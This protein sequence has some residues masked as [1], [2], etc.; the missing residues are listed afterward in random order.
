MAT[1]NLPEVALHVETMGAGEAL[2]FISGLGGNASFWQP[3]AE[4]FAKNYRVV[5]HDHRGTGASSRLATAYS[6]E[7]MAQDV[8][9]LMDALEIEKAH[10]VGHSTGGAIGQVLAATA[11]ERVLSLV[12][13]ASWSVMCAQ[14]EMC[15][16]ARR[17][18]LRSMGEAE[19]HRL[20]PLFLYPPY[21]VQANKLLLESDTEKAIVGTTTRDILDARITAIME[22]DGLPYLK[23]IHCPTLIM[24]AEDDILT[25][26]HSSVLMASEIDNAVLRRYARGGHSMSRTEPQ[27]FNKGVSDFLSQL[28]IVEESHHV[29]A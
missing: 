20:S 7:L 17:R 27:Q 4:L 21:Y 13:Y 2:F 5:L 1:I 18:I 28:R 11:P 12:L 22:F 6:V 29:D 8:I 16:D 23:D 10:F 9:G 14:M 24:V 3:Q 19:Y 26:P 25:P 15:L